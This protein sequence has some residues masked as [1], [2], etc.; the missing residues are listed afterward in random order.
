MKHF[1]KFLTFVTII[2]GIC[3][4]EGAT[5]AQVFS[6][7]NRTLKQSQN[8]EKSLKTALK[9]VENK[10]KISIMANSEL[11]DGKTVMIDKMNSIE[12]TLTSLTHPHRLS[13]EKISEKQYVI[14]SMQST[15]NQPFKLERSISQPQNNSTV[16]IAN[17]VSTEGNP[18]KANNNIEVIIAEEIKGKITSSDGEPLPGASVF[19]KNSPTT[20][21]TTDANGN[22]K[23]SV[24]KAEG[25]LVI[26]YIG[27]DTRNIEISGRK[28]INVALNPD[29]RNLDEIVVVGYGTQKRS[30]LTGAVSGVKAEDLKN[31]P[32]QNL[33]TLLQGRVPGIFVTNDDGN[34]NSDSKIVIRGP[35]SINGGDPLVVVDGVPFQGTGF[36]FN[37]QDIE[38]V[39]ILKDAAAAAI[40]GA[41]AAAGVIL[42]TTKKGKAG[43]MRIGLNATYGVRNVFNLPKTLRRDDYLRAKEA[44]GF[45]VVDLYGPKSG[46]SG[47][48]NTDW[49]NEM[50]R[51]GSEQTY[52]L[53]LSGGGDKSTFFISGNYSNIQ[54]T[55]IGNGIEKYNLRINTDHKINKWINFGQTLFINNVIEDPDNTTNQ[56]GLSFRNTPIMKVYDDTNP[57]GGWGRSPRG[58]QGGHDVQSALGNTTQARKWETTL[59]GYLDFRILEG[60]NFRTLLG[61]SFE[62]SDFDSY[63]PRADIGSSIIPERFDKNQGRSQKLI[64]TFTL[65]YDKTIGQHSFKALAGYEARKEDYSVM[66]YGNI[67]P[68]VPNPQNSNL[69][70]NVSNATSNFFKGGI[71]N[72]ILSQ[73]GRIE[74]AYAGKYLLTANLRRDGIATKF[75]PNNRFGV[76]PGVSAGW[77]I[78]DEAFMRE[79]PAVS[80]LKLR[81]SYGVLGNSNIPDFL[82]ASAYEQGYSAD[83][84]TS[85]VRQ[86]SIGV[87][88]R[89]ANP[90]IQWE[91]VATTNIGID[92]AFLN[93][94]LF[95]NIDYY[96]RQ[97]NKM[98][99]GLSIA[100][101]AGLG[102]EVRS[103]IGQMSNTGLELNLEW[104]NKSGDFT[105]SIGV[106]GSFNANKLISLNP[107]LGRQ[108]L[109]NGSIGV[110]HYEGKNASRSEPGQPLGQFYGYNVLG[111][112]QNNASA[113]EKRPTISAKDNYV[114]RSGDL[115]YQD[116][117]SDGKINDDDRTYIGNPWPKLTYGINLTAAYKGFDLRV[118]FSGVQGNQ[119]YNAYESFEYMFFSD[120]TVTNKIFDVSGFAGNGVTG[121]P[122]IGKIDDLDNNGNWSAVSSYHVQD[123]SYLRLK[124]IQFGYTLPSSILNSMKISSA[125]VFVMA[126]NL[127]TLT[128]YKGV[129]PEIGY[130]RDADANNRAFLEL[131][132]DAA[133]RRYPMSKL[134]SFGLNL[135][136]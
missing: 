107:E 80:S 15:K 21:T 111:I 26:S 49:F 13:F 78:S 110:E 10:F 50:Y 123:G 129:N 36:N 106:N 29:Q 42:V 59:T 105:Y 108:F 82:F 72:R 128:G 83:V 41:Q 3:L 43:Q 69:V 99:Y 24:P 31:L 27:Y 51:Q 136:F 45:D 38:N 32:A 65:S 124:N 87:A 22:Y 84:G 35:V 73:F 102:S 92:G 44:Y 64:G 90:D 96:S 5:M 88:T 120:Y 101:S 104:R 79:L 98:L 95:F 48:P 81:A 54:G 40:Y 61:T 118:F 17:P 85:G 112:Y 75:G 33:G 93:N 122:R 89:L 55:K 103:N 134:L 28:E 18:T 4:C 30:S 12:E 37:G 94:K 16:S 9:E 130:K 70:K 58:F 76:F 62:N 74:Y 86:T 23:L 116:L 7:S 11:L 131:G 97:T 71:G 52:N 20:G 133:N 47:L 6:A 119:I 68:L 114:P 60:L 53:S 46:W 77:K 117:N 125:R 121:V 1:T 19:L 100:P 135:Q 67:D 113:T 25:T 126:D 8:V 34:P 56:G 132:I 2:S 127:L 57:I 66:N 14:F 39:E 109:P 91:E 115:I 63:T